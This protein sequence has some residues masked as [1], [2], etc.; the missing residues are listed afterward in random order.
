VLARKELADVEDG[1][2]PRVEFSNAVAALAWSFRG[3]PEQAR[4]YVRRLEAE[5]AD[6]RTSPSMLARVYAVQGKTGDALDALE[7]SEVQ[8]DRE[9]MYLSVSPLYVHIRNEP[10]FVAIIDR[11]NLPR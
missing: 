9:L 2:P 1:K 10:R 6:G 7:A 3:S 4:P 5:L 8:H 11:M